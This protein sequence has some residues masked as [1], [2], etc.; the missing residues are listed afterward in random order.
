MF[1]RIALLAAVLVGLLGGTALAEDSLFPFVISYDAP[2]NVTDLSG[3]LERPARPVRSNGVAQV[4]I[5]STPGR[6]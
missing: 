4:Q 1:A 5:A 6:F 3:W 2:E